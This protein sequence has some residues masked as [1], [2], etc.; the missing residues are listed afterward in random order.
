MIKL[1]LHSLSKA[2][3]LF[4]YGI[5]G[6]LALGLQNIFYY[7]CYKYW[8][9][10]PAL[11]MF[12]AK[13]LGVSLSYFGHFKYTFRRRRHELRVVIKHLLVTLFGFVFAVESVHL[14]TYNFKLNPIFGIIPSLLSP[15][16]T[17]LL[18]RFWTFGRH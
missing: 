3:H 11:A 18:T 13:I 4:I 6:L 10:N 9:L 12:M 8:L 17:Y 7:L 14:I 5:V 1:F 16:I 15:I 2:P